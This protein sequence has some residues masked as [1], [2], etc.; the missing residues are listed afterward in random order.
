MP[1]VSI[2]IPTYKR[3]ELLKVALDSCL[4]QTFKDFEV[5]IC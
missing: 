2:C 3:P 5:V 4:A 1:K